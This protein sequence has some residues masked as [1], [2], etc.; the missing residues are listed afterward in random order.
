[1]KKLF[2]SMIASIS[3][4][5]AQSQQLKELVFDYS[6]VWKPTCIKKLYRTQVV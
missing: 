3:L 4:L 6:M 1:M 5:F 2:L